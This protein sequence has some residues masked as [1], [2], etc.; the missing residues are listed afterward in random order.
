MIIY[1]NTGESEEL[2][3]VLANRHL[4]KLLED[5]NSKGSAS[6]EAEMEKAM[7]E[8][9]FTEFAEA[10]LKIIE[11]KSDLKLDFA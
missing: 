7:H 11:P 5:I 6:I 4:R 9:I 1:G 8:P 10:C 2:K 3:N